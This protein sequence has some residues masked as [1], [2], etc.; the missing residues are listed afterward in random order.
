MT[1]DRGCPGFDWLWSHD[2]RCDRCGRGPWEHDHMMAVAGSHGERRRGSLAAKPWPPAIVAD[3]LHRN[4]ITPARA[5]QLTAAQ[6]PRNPDTPT[7]P[8]P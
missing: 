6:P 7:G 8:Q 5:T 3:W 2:A 1:A 4:L